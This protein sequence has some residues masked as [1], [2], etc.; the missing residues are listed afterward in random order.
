MKRSSAA[1]V[2]VCIMGSTMIRAKAQ[3]TSA[4]DPHSGWCADPSLDAALVNHLRA[5][6]L[7][8]AH[9]L[10]QTLLAWCPPSES[11]ARW[12]LIDGLALDELDEPVR[13]RE[14]FHEVVTTGSPDQR[15]TGATLLARSYLQAGD[16]GAFGQALARLPARA[17]TRLR[18]LQA[19]DD[20]SAFQS[21]LPQL[22]D[23]QLAVAVLAEG[24]RYQQAIHTRRPWLAGTLSAV[25]PGM[26]QAYAGSWQGAAV[27]LVINALL[28]GATV[29]LARRELYVTAGAAGLA[30][31]IF[32]L[33]NVLNAA[34]L[35]A[36]RN[37]R[38]ALPHGEALE[39]LLL[40]EAYP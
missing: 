36:R 9:Q 13:A 30:A 11:R 10:A 39:R 7:L 6:N 19:R 25:V 3:A 21:L 23:Q 24:S 1:A 12:Q 20:S 17:S 27:A 16:E 32:Y 2:L 33:G 40:P 34:D 28:I 22:R 31:S 29:E 8:D 35:A 5:R 26:G 15:Q 4:V 14:A 38:A 37:E 18:L